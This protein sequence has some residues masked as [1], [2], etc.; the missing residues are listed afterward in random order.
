MLIIG[1]KINGRTQLLPRVLGL[2]L[3]LKAADAISAPNIVDENLRRCVADIGAKNNWAT[4]DQYQHITCHNKAIGAVDGLE[5]FV[6]ITKLSLHKNQ[7]KSFA[8]TGLKHLRTLNLGRNRLQRLTIGNL[9]ALE[10]LYIFSN[11]LTELTMSDLPKLTKLKANSNNIVT[12]T[13]RDLPALGKIYL[14]DNAMEHIDIHSLP[15]LKYMDVRQNPMPD[16]L[17]EAMD[18]L[19]GATILHDGNADD[20]S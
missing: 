4:P 1:H 5:S 16:E 7:I 6:N 18:K 10:E 19:E 13:Y 14:F 2:F 8:L 20:W 12:F 3:L 11:R 15:N 17:Y 9:A